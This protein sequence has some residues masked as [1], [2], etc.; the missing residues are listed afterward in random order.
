MI[1]C[2]AGKTRLIF[3]IA[4]EIY[5]ATGKKVILTSKFEKAVK[6]GTQHEY[7]LLTKELGLPKDWI[8]RETRSW[9][10]YAIKSNSIP[11]NIGGILIDEVQDVCPGEYTQ[12]LE[13]VAAEY[14][15]GFT[16]SLVRSDGATPEILSWV[17]PVVYRMSRQ[18]A[19]TRGYVTCPTLVQHEFVHP[20]F[21]KTMVKVKD[22]DGKDTDQEVEKILIR[23]PDGLI[24][25]E[26]LYCSAKTERVDVL[27][28]ANWM[29]EQFILRN[30][31]R[32]K[33][34]VGHV[35]EI[36]EAGGNSIMLFDDKAK[37]HGDKL[38]KEAARYMGT[39]VRV[40]TGDTKKKEAQKSIDDFVSGDARVLITTVGYR[41][42]DLPCATDVFVCGVRSSE[43]FIEQAAGRLTRHTPVWVKKRTTHIHIYRDRGHPI[44][45]S[46]AK[47]TR[48]HLIG[49]GIQLITEDQWRSSLNAS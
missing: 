38:F 12:I 17:G 11:E 49:Q 9:V 23:T 6:R 45:M 29:S 24:D 15:Y 33:A 34:I 7:K 19:V 35:R 22:K 2:G 36:F 13:N 48:E 30:E 21:E 26:K 31:V 46:R 25:P 27:S 40:V 37:G 10:A 5:R 4:L 1:P 44:L 47:R 8:I 16:A 43:E 42:L 28:M 18:L 20:E 32:T 3:A 14:V 39:W 41:S